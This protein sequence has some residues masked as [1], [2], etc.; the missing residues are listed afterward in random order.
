MWN[1][2]IGLMLDF[3]LLLSHSL[4]LELFANVD[5]GEFISLGTLCC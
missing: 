3:N 2:F 5:F 1:E 4:L